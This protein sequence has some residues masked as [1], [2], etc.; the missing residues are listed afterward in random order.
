MALSPQ[1]GPE[2]DDSAFVFADT[3]GS[4][5]RAARLRRR[6]IAVELLV[7]LFGA[8]AVGALCGLILSRW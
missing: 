5:L 6:R 4:D 8:L 3:L 1:P 2:D 7:T